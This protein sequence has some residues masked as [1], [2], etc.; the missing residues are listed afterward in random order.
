[1][2]YVK[3]NMVI[4][5]IIVIVIVII[6]VITNVKLNRTLQKFFVFLFICPKYI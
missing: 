1:M 6:I 5:I 3:Q 4:V 2:R